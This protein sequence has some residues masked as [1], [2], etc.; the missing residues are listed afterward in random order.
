MVSTRFRKERHPVQV[1]LAVFCSSLFAVGLLT[2]TLPHSNKCGIFF[3]HLNQNYMDQEFLEYLK[4]AKKELVKNFISKQQ[5][6]ADRVLAENFVIAF[7]QLLDKQKM[8]KQMKVGIYPPKEFKDNI[9]VILLYAEKRAVRRASILHQRQ[10]DAWS[11][12]EDTMLEARLDSAIIEL[13]RTASWKKNIKII[14]ANAH[15]ALSF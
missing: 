13:Q 10:G 1:Y 6:T 15:V 7:D 3:Y 9:A 2:H 11:V 4:T 14:A 12:M 8:G 5:T